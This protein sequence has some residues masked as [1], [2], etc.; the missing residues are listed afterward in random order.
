[1]ARP[2]SFDP[3]AALNRAKNAFW[4]SGFD[5]T[6]MHDL[7]AA[8]GLN[9]QSL[10]R[11][12]GDKR[13]LYR[14]ALKDYEAHEMAEAQAWLA[15]EGAA[16]ARVARLLDGVIDAAMAADDR[17]GCF[18][19]NA[20]VD[21]AGDDPQTTAWISEAIGALR[22]AL[23]AALAASPPYRDDEPRRRAKAAELA[24]TYLGL[25]ALIRAGQPEDVL[26]AVAAQAVA[27][28]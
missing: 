3:G 27:G 15:A 12:F 7:E 8:T 19:C 22:A 24:A 14:R 26:R 1:M 21:D 11:E 13:A 28:V 9:K 4:R 18:L 10:Y 16:R 5:G 2:R 25:R 23:A 17:R 20:I 6:S